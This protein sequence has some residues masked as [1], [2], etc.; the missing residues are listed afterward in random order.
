MP[1][2][3]Y[4]G[5]RKAAEKEDDPEHLKRNLENGRWAS[6]TAGRRWEWQLKTQLD[7]VE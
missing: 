4:S 7:R 5:H 2:K 1:S 6:G 3:H